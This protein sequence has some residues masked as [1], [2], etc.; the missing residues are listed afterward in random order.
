MP[1]ML[2]LGWCVEVRPRMVPGV[3]VVPAYRWPAGVRAPLLLSGLDIPMPPGVEAK[4]ARLL[5]RLDAAA[6]GG[7]PWAEGGL[8]LSRA[9]GERSAAALEVGRGIL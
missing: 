4:L 5:G 1:P 7:L 8:L 2:D 6:E 3:V 9:E